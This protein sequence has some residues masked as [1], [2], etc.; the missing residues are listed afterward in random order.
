M[1]HEEASM[2]MR[3]V[4]VTA[5]TLGWSEAGTAG[6]PL[7]VGDPAPRQADMDFIKGD[8]VA[9]LDRGKVYVIEFWG[10]WCGPCRAIIPHLTRLQQKHKDVI[11][12]GVSAYER[13]PKGVKAFVDRM[14]DK[15]AYRV[16]LDT[17]SEGAEP[18]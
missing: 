12:I 1:I 11:F 3:F 7:K 9:R 10:T 16:A 15:M 4:I 2:S 18:R 17:V 5:E 6:E 14:G 8:R 13:D